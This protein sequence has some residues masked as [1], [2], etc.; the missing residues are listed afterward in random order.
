M[1]DVRTQSD[2]F[3]DTPETAAVMFTRQWLSDDAWRATNDAIFQR[4][5]PPLPD[6]VDG[7]T[8]P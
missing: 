7:V 5:I 4:L 3:E 6:A 8:S 2:V 1:D